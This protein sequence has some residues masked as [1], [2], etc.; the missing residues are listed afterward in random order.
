MNNF[1]T[2]TRS[3]FTATLLA[4]IAIVGLASTIRAQPGNDSIVAGEGVG[5]LAVGAKKAVILREFGVPDESRKIKSAKPD[6]YAAYFAKGF[7]VEYVNGIVTVIHFIGDAS[8]YEDG[9]TKFAAFFGLPDKGLRWRSSTADVMKVYGTP[10]KRKDF[11]ESKTDAP[12]TDLTYSDA[13]F[14][15]KMDQ[16]FQIDVIKASKTP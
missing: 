11:N 5:P 7:A 6:T 13:I 16:L 8:L 10:V 9:K 3:L 12:L 4:V 14:R 15:F 1:A 2:S